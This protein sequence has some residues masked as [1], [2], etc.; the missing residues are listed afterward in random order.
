MPSRDARPGKSSPPGRNPDSSLSLQV[1]PVFWKA[2]VADTLKVE[3]RSSRGSAPARKLRQQG[4][5][6][7][8]LYGHGEENVSL[9]VDWK[10]LDAVLKHSGHVV[11][12][13][14]AISESALI[15]DLQWDHVNQSCLHVD[16]ARV[17]ADELVEVGLEIVLKGTAKGA[18]E[19]GVVNHIVHEVAIKCPANRIPERLELN[20][21]SLD[22]NGSLRAKDLVLPD[23]ASLAVSPEMTLATCNLPVVIA[24]PVVAGPGV[25]S[26][27]EPSVIEKGKKDKEGE[28]AASATGK[29]D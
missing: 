8:V 21:T 23:G 5:V 27:A 9:T 29:K 1:Y 18:S 28:G 3:K 11:Q 2:T 24:E 19:G 25:V 22:L 26:T 6:P 12:L 4:R 16:F 15:K 10:E 7:G 14:G 20:L 17:S 13:T